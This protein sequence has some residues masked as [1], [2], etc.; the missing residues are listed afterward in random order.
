MNG[1]GD[2]NRKGDTTGGTDGMNGTGE[3]TGDKSDTDG[4]NGAGDN[5]GTG[6]TTGDRNDKNDG[7]P[8]HTEA[9]IP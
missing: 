9:E 6:D 4:M 7:S 8:Q 1:A 2:K 5:N 3:S